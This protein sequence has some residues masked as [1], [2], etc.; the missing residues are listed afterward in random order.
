MAMIGSQ[1]L[2]PGDT[3][4]HANYWPECANGLRTDAAR[5]CIHECDPPRTALNF[6]SAVLLILHVIV[7]VWTGRTSAH[8]NI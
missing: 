6:L 5:S 7:T 3:V 4:T 1:T 8:H 2:S